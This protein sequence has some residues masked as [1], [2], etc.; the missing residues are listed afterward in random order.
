MDQGTMCFVNV[1]GLL[2]VMNPHDIRPQLFSLKKALINPL[3]AVCIK[4]QVSYQLVNMCSGA[5]R[6]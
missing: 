5:P 1:K 2:L 3:Y 6:G 4:Q